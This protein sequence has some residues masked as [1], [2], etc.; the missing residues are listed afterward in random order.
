MNASPR[1]GLIR[2]KG[3]ATTMEI[4]ILGVCG[5]PIKGGNTEVFLR[6]ALKAAED[7][8]GVQT[9]LILLAGKDIKDCRHCNWCV[10][11]QIEGKFCAQDDDMT[12]IY[13]KILQSDGLL[14]ASPVYFHR[15]SGYLACFMDRLRAFAHSKVYRGALRNKVGGALSVAWFRNEGVET[16]LM[17]L[18]DGFV[19]SDMIPVGM[20]GGLSTEHGLGEFD[21]QDKLGVLKDEY[22]LGKA[23]SVGERAAEIAKLLKVGAK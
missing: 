17:S 19:A 11:K 16:T 12:G 1:G 21:P 20:A 15:L 18:L 13:P 3:G 6:E 10:T 22:G 8:G 2:L 9:E 5:S 7:A 4:K 23:R 14:L